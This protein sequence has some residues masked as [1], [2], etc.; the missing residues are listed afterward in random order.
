MSEVS[1]SLD[2]ITFAQQGQLVQR[3]QVR[4]VVN[5]KNVRWLR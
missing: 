1:G 2:A 4:L 3:A 5:D